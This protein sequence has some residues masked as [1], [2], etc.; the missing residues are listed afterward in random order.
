LQNGVFKM[1]MFYL[2][3]FRVTFL[4]KKGIFGRILKFNIKVDIFDGTVT[5]QW[6]KIG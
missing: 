3:L 6:A 4:L 1:I 2:R 5:D